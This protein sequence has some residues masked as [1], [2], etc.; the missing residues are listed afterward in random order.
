M[1]KFIVS[2]RKYRPVR[3]DQVIGQ[4]SITRTLKNAIRQKQLAHAYLFC[5]P[6]GVGKTT[7]AR[8]F[9]KTIN[10]MNL[11]D[12]TEACNAC[13]S[14]LAFNESRSYNIHE[15]DA[16]SNNK[17]EDIR[18]LIDQIRV[19][20]QIG[21]YSIYIIDEVHMLS[22]S[23][24]NAFLK[25]LEE[26]PAHAIFILATTQKEKII[27]TILSRCQIFDFHRIRVPD[28]MNHLQHV[29]E[30]E[31][32]E[33]EP[34]AMN[35]I[36][37]KADGAMR[38]ALSVFDQI[39]SYSGKKMSYE[40]VIESLNVLDYE[41][42]FK[43][44]AAFLEGNVTETML[45]F[46]EIMERGFDPQHFIVGLTRHFRDLLMCKDQQT[47]SL[48]DVAASIAGRYREQTSLT[49]SGFL[50]RAL[51]ICNEC[52]IAYRHSKDQR[53]HVEIALIKLCRLAEK[54]EKKEMNAPSAK[55]VEK[56]ES[57]SGND[58]KQVK[59]NNIPP[60][61]PVM[62]DNP[63]TGKKNV[64]TNHSLS[65]KDV[66]GGNKKK[67]AS[68]Q[69]EKN[70]SA[71]PAT[72]TEEAGAN[73]FSPEQLTKAWTGFAESVKE[74]YPRIYSAMKNQNLQMNEDFVIPLIMSNRVQE[75]DFNREVRPDLQKH[76]RRELGNKRITIKTTVLE[77]EEKTQPYTSEEK[78]EHMSKKNPVL[79]DLKQKFN[80]DFD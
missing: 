41:Y 53:L 1:G 74:E 20:P 36:A 34:E 37:Q 33:A 25:T 13:E 54:K 10:C 45:L 73:D 14:C 76:L 5:G 6:R 71:D 39:S 3:F 29:A 49:S 18:N 9:A 67:Y 30:K 22:A 65:I 63:D 77:D 66:L 23:A 57:G 56:K 7:C 60:P 19:P 31:G 40:K 58:E 46:N 68:V 27:P 35:I 72:E 44:T 12:D 75:E 70:T 59:K 51:D 4:E 42:Y 32:I 48:M 52:D 61:S 47:F 15:L 16:A 2:A 69:E 50:F 17:V 38:D 11:G 24:F 62:K 43:M 64:Y 78:F 8:L 21:K 80:L 28:I 55:P 79:K 26:P